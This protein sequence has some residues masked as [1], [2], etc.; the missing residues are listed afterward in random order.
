[1]ATGKQKLKRILAAAVLTVLIAVLVFSPVTGSAAPGRKVGSA[2]GQEPEALTSAS[3]QAHTNVALVL[4]AE[5]LEGRTDST[6]GPYGLG[7]VGRMVTESIDLTGLPGI[8][9]GSSVRKVVILTDI[10][11]PVYDSAVNVNPHVAAA[12]VRKLYA[13]DSTLSI[14][15]ACAPEHWG[16]PESA[17]VPDSL[18]VDGFAASGFTRMAVSLVADL[19]AL[20][21]EL[22]DLNTDSTQ[23][24]TAYTNLL[25]EEWTAFE[26]A[27]RVAQADYV[28]MLARLKTGPLGI[29]CALTSLKLALPGTV[30]GWPR[31]ED[32]GPAL[33][34]ETLVSLYGAVRVDYL[35]VDALYCLEGAGTADEGVKVVGAVMAGEDLVAVD[36]VA[37]RLAGFDPLDMEYL[38]LAGEL[39]MGLVDPEL[40]TILGEVELPAG[41]V[42][43]A[44]PKRTFASSALANPEYP[45]QGQGVRRMLYSFSPDSAAA[46][47][48]GEVCLP[49][50]SLDGWAGPERSPDETLGPG[51]EIQGSASFHGFT[52][53]WCPEEAEAELWVGS[54]CGLKVIVDGSLVLE[55]RVSGPESLRVPDEVVELSLP[56]G[57]GTIE[58]F[59]SPGDDG[60]A[61]GLFSLQLTGRADER[62]YAGSR[63]PG[64]VFF[65][66]P[67]GTEDQAGVVGTAGPGYY[68]RSAAS[69]GC[70]ETAHCGA[71]GAYVFKELSP[72]EVE[73]K[74]FNDTGLLV[75][76]TTVYLEEYRN[77]RVDF[78]NLGHAGPQVTG[79]YSGDGDLAVNDVIAL[80]IGML[81][82]PGDLYYDFNGDGRANVADAIALLLAMR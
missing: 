49:W 59:A 22:V 29:D 79:D 24:I 54:R 10:S 50:D 19:P 71:R 61:G 48:S 20:Q 6:A 45:Y 32:T 70:T 40:I 51:V 14:T 33:V 36:A 58:V 15:L 3:L 72:G 38:G 42:L 7:E 78:L 62:K 34:D 18:R 73:L 16:S 44:R 11:H 28:I 67:G 5:S 21:L 75:A 65:T 66:D 8:Y 25:T 55:R 64:L 4:A 35:L 56:G 63:V 52:Y 46:R 77:L 31:F 57:G 23:S 76:D 69:C 12:L 53:Y 13:V 9:P 2:S 41:A 74:V 43:L 30:Y 81:D 60:N 39:A 27:A 47:D 80:L 17:E 26:V 68:V 82:R 1:M 37:A